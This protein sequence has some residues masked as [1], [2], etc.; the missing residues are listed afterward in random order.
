LFQRQSTNRA[1]F[2]PDLI[3]DPDIHR[4]DRLFPAL[5]LFSV[6]GPPMLGGLL[7][8]SW[9]GALTAFIWATLVRVALLH[10]G[11]SWHNSHPC[12]PDLRPPR[13]ASWPD[14]SVSPGHLG[15]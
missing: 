6:A 11:E 1:R 2:A 12:R 8:W 15:L 10:L 14:R 4:V 9:Y 3:A 13:R 7:T 5:A